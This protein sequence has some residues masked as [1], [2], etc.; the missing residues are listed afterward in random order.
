M[1]W[2][3]RVRDALV[4]TYATTTKIPKHFA[5][6]DKRKGFSERKTF[7]FN[8]YQ[9]MMRENELVV[10]FHAENLNVKLLSEIRRQV[11]HIKVPD[12]DLARLEA[13]NHGAPWTWPASAFT[14]ARTGLLRPVCRR[15]TAESIQ[16]LEPYLHGQMAMLTCPVLSPEYVGKVL[17]AI[18]RPV[19]AAAN[20]VDPKSEKKAPL[21]RP[22]VAVAERARVIDA[23]SLPAFTQLPNLATLRAQLVGLLSAPGT[24]LAGILSQ[25]GGGELAATLE[26]R[27]RD[28]EA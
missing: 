3:Q 20:D 22:L 17:R 7:L 5:Y 26:A 23:K 1:V 11:S 4:R 28:L 19:T 16:A 8:K 27:R 14:M 15:D 25:A 2:T 6:Q 9:R 21:L 24:Q 12:A 18:E 10:L 13:L